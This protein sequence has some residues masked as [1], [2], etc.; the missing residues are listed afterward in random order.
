MG[1]KVRGVIAIA[2]GF[3]ALWQSYVYY[4]RRG[5]DWHLW[6][7]AVAGALL[8]CIGVWRFRRKP[9]DLTSELLK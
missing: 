9:A 4:Q 8:I 6:F 1:D 7:E 5:V 3:F 2:V